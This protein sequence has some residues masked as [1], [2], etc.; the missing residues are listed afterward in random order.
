MSGDS[1]TPTRLEDLLSPG[2][3]RL[4][5]DTLPGL[6][7]GTVCEQVLQGADS[8]TGGYHARIRR[9][10][11]GDPVLFSLT[12]APVTAAGT[13]DEQF[14]Q[15]VEASPSGIVLVDVKG[16]IAL[17]NRTLELCFGYT[18]QELLGMPVENLLPE[19]LR[20]G[21][22]ADLRRALPAAPRDPPDG[23]GP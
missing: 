14:R 11:D 12:L 17:V 4:L 16:N 20:H 13:G 7:P 10:A 6:A 15:L 1:P 19:R 22:H 18:R 2:D 21:Q 9:V 3:C 23:G 5:A 8:R